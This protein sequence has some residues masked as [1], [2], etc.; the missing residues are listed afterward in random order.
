M[1]SDFFRHE[2][3]LVMEDIG[4][5]LDEIDVEW[6]AKRLF[7]LIK[8]EFE[9]YYYKFGEEHWEV[10]TSYEHPVF[11]KFPPMKR[12]GRKKRRS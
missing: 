10:D 5:M 3:Y 2:N 12:L 8:L 1:M 11:P 4:R 7:G 6:E 9:R